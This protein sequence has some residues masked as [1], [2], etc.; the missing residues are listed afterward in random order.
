[1]DLGSVS[2]GGYVLVA[3]AAFLASLLG[4]VAGYGSG[5]IL[6]PLLVPLVG[7]EAVVPIIAVSALLTNTSRLVAYRESFDRRRALLIVVCAVPTCLLGAYGFTLLSGPRVALLIGVVL[8][9][10]VPARRLLLQPGRHLSRRSLAAASVGY[11]ALLGG[12]TGSGV[13]LLSILLAAGLNP[14]AVIAT[15]AGISLVLGLAKVTV[16]QVAGELPV[17]SWAMAL[18][19]GIAGTPGAF[20]ARRLSSG[21]SLRSHVWI[22]DGAVLVGATI[23][24]LQGLT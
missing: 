11:G 18:T 24:I 14:A 6:P 1:M 20:I 19:I 3:L 4:G 7:A 5:L 10:M 13:I 9:L 22:I 17:S 2:P 15:D 23:L 8:A 12:T 16:F 21:L